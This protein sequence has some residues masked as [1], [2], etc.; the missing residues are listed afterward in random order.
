MQITDGC[1]I[2]IML[3]HN[4]RAFRAIVLLRMRAEYSIYSFSTFYCGAN[5][6]WKLACTPLGEGDALIRRFTFTRIISTWFR[7]RAE[8][9]CRITVIFTIC[10]L[11]EQINSNNFGNREAEDFP[12][13]FIYTSYTIRHCFLTHWVFCWKHINFLNSSNGSKKIIVLYYMPLVNFSTFASSGRPQVNMCSN[14]HQLVCAKCILM[15]LASPNWF[16][17]LRKLQNHRTTILNN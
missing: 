11:G 17:P 14:L 9:I 6:N 16:C 4:S 1:N 13:Y 12:T 10:N 7:S 8:H 15:Q 3:R 5:A 2:C